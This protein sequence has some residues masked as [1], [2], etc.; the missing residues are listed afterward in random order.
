M[1]VIPGHGLT[2]LFEDGVVAVYSVDK[3]M[4]EARKLASEYRKA[5]GKPLS[6]VTPEIALHDVIRLMRLEPAAEAAAGWDATGTGAREG[7]RILVKGR[8]IFDETKG[9]QRI[10]QLKLDKDWDSVML[11]LMD[12]QYEPCEI[13]EAERQD[14]ID[15]LESAEGSNRARRGVMS[16]AKF[17]NIARLVWSREDGIIEDEIWDNMAGR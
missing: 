7:K 16:V 1:P 10:G 15:A 8:A 17:R 2:P 12:E 13:Y 11:L 4:A 9:G 14:I 6:G 5:T 3:L